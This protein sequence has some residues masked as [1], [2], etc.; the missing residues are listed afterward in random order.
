MLLADERLASPMMAGAFCLLTGGGAEIASLRSTT[1]PGLGTE[2]GLSLGLA[3]VAGRRLRD[4]AGGFL[5]AAGEAS[6]EGVDG[7][8]GACA[9]LLPEVFFGD[10]FAAAGFEAGASAAESFETAC[11]LLSTAACAAEAPS[12]LPPVERRLRRRR[13]F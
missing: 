10:G 13:R 4:F 3:S 11:V 12:A 1:P 7:F 8:D 6:E 5:G 9:A 2:T